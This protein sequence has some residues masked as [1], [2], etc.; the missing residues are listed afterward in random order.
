M[1]RTIAFCL[2]LVLTK[3]AYAGDIIYPVA[4]I[5]TSL[6]KDAN[7]VKRKDETRFEIINTHET[8]LRKLYA[9]TILNEAGLDEAQFVAGYDKLRKIQSIEGSLYD[10]KGVLL[11]R[12][13]PKD[14]QDYSNVSDIS[15]MEDNRVKVHNFNYKEF[16]FTVEYEVVIKSTTTYGLP[17]W[18][19]VS[20][21]HLSVE[22]SMFSLVCPDDYT[23]RYKA[24]NYATEPVSTT[25]SG[26]KIMVWKSAN[27]AAITKPFASPNWYELTTSVHFAPSFFEMEDFKGNGASW[28]E[29]GKFQ[30]ALNQNRDKLPEPVLQKVK[31]LT[32]GITDDREKVKRLYEFL[33]QNTRYISIQLGIGGL[34]PFDAGYV[35]QKG[36]GDC[37]ALSNYMYSLL[38]AAGI[39]SHHTLVNG[40][41]AADDRYMIED[42]PS[43][44]FNHMILCVPMAKDSIWLECTSQSDPAGYMGS[45]TGN[46]KVLLIT[47]EGGKLVSTPRY[48]L[49]ENLQVRSL[50]GKLDE[51]GNLAMKVATSYRATQQDRIFSM[52]TELSKDKLKE[53]LNEE[54]ELSS[55]E[56]NDFKYASKKE[57]LPEVDETLD[58]TVNNY[59]TITGK[60]LF[61][62]PNVLNRSAVQLIDEERSFDI[63]FSNEYR[64]VDSVEIELLD[65]YEIEA[66]PQAVTLKTAYGSYKASYQVQKSKILY[67]REREQYAGRFPA[68]EYKAVINFYNAIYKADRNRLVLVRKQ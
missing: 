65:G 49:K 18:A 60:R 24:F 40:G 56:V 8:I 53:V 21:Q 4:T 36:Y 51:T 6:L 20:A 47:E 25:A 23:V 61:I 34:Q 41:R 28:Q 54:L 68:S 43:H 14:I 63:Q 44:Q 55:Y 7:V 13:K 35:A 5:P 11:K 67:V 64:D 26:K 66:L 57:A 27:L 22:N 59:A 16:P 45:F 1:T 42:L 9:I 31:Q 29:F 58:V 37:K 33:Q 3:I 62:V 19:P 10:A 32:D 2:F 48:G 38:K 46:R 39:R 15:I 17:V 50:K 30:L 52:I 12:L